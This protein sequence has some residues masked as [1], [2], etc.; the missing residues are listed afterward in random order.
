MKLKLNT[1]DAKLATK[2]PSNIYETQYMLFSVIPVIIFILYFLAAI[3]VY[4]D[5]DSYVGILQ[6]TMQLY[7]GI[8]LF[9]RFNPFLDRPNF[10]ELDRKVAYSAGL[11]IIGTTLV[12]ILVDYYHNNPK[13]TVKKEIQDALNK[14]PFNYPAPF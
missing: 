5:S 6:K 4:K 3:G 1:L 7:I 8:F 10:S 2:L 13:E 11:F 9:V 14:H 12:K